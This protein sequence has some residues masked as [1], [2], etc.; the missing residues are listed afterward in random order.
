MLR[1]VT[2]DVD[3]NPKWKLVLKEYEILHRTCVRR[4]GNVT[5]FFLKKKTIEGCNFVVADTERGTGIGN[6][7]LS[8]VSIFLYALLTQRV[9]LVP[10]ATAIPGVMCEPFEGSSWVIDPELRNFT[11][12][13]E[14]PKL[15]GTVSNSTRMSIVASATTTLPQSSAA[16]AGTGNSS[17][18]IPLPDMILQLAASCR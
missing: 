18:E 7:L 9:M 15:W 14:N 16:A 6:K 3:E 10:F 12:A 17:T 5:E 1:K 4:M 11:Q 8:I 2:P 13:R